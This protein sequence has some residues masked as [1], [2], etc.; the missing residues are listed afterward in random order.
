MA[1]VV[2]DKVNKTFM[3]GSI[4]ALA[5]VT[6]EIPHERFVTVLGPSGCGKSTLLRVVA[7]LETPD[8]GQILLGER[9]VNDVPPGKRNVAMVFQNYALY[10]HMK[11]SDNVAIGLRLRHYTGDEIQRRVGKVAEMLGIGKVLGRYPRQLSG[12]QQQRVALAR[13]LVREP[14]VFLLDEPLSNLDA[15]I[16]DQTRTELK[17]LFKD[18]HATVLYVTHD[19][20]EAMSMSDVVVVMDSGQV[21]QVADPERIYGD[22]RHQFVAEFVG[23]YR[24]NILNGTITGGRFVSNDGSMQMALGVAHQGNVSVGIRPESIYIGKEGGI[25]LSTRVMHIE[26]LGANKMVFGKT[27][28]NELRVL[29][30]AGMG[31]RIGDSLPVSVSPRDIFLFDAQDKRRIDVQ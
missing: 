28:A 15:Q 23:T 21:R 7:G 25:Q 3:Q 9:V 31:V 26:P 12:G 29:G 13:A 10:P 19:Q 18:L 16:R 11:V 2:L 8:S 14:E 20:V 24:I 22:P 17:R 5:E 6:L 30:A 1:K 4:I 27:G